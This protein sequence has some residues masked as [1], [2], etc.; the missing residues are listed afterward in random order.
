MLRECH[1]IPVIRTLKGRNLL[2]WVQVPL[3]AQQSLITPRCEQLRDYSVHRW[4]VLV[5][6]CVLWI[7][8]IFVLIWGLKPGS[9]LPACTS[10]SHCPKT[11]YVKSHLFSS[12]NATQLALRQD[13]LLH[14]LLWFKGQR[15]TEAV[16]NLR[17][18]LAYV[19]WLSTGKLCINIFLHYA[20]PSPRT[21][22]R[23]RKALGRCAKQG[24]LQILQNC[25]A[26]LCPRWTCRFNLPR[27][28]SC[29]AWSGAGTEARRVQ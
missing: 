19:S 7:F 13:C 16:A 21:W 24:E 6:C 14:H 23:R 5:C 8:L 27:E 29:S 9:N 22:S 11:V 18:P 26:D 4:N 17:K 25:R 15:F 28:G 3:T 2:K 10:D 20:K 12:D 1:N